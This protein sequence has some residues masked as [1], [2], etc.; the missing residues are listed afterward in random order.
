MKNFC[1][2]MN[3]SFSE[4]KQGS[5]DIFF[6]LS[7]IF[8]AYRICFCFAHSATC[9]NSPTFFSFYGE[10]FYFL[11]FSGSFLAVF[12]FTSMFFNVFQITLLFFCSPENIN[13]RQK[14]NH[15]FGKILKLVPIKL[16]SISN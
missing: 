9:S 14:L 12:L 11:H 15:N 16:I 8:S 13:V 5:S 6:I 3:K 7:M 1:F 2:Q 4:G 10:F